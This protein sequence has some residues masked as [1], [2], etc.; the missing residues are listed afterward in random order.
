MASINVISAST[1]GPVRLVRSLSRARKYKS[2]V[3]AAS[4]PKQTLLISYSNLKTKLTTIKPKKQRLD[5]RQLS[6]YSYEKIQ[7]RIQADKIRRDIKL[8]KK[9]SHYNSK[10]DLAFRQYLGHLVN[11][12]EILKATCWPFTQWMAT[13][14]RGR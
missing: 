5:F 9:S 7:D 10:V 13:H 2:L 11:S 1:V 4:S 12:K 3:K 8:R 6:F 14:S